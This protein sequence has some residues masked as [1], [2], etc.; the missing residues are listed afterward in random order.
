MVAGQSYF[1]CSY[2]GVGALRLSSGAPPLCV[3][4]VQTQI[5][6]QS[7]TP[8]TGPGLRELPQV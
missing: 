7:S 2:Q 8:I 1:V 3:I 6:M 5:S 4:E